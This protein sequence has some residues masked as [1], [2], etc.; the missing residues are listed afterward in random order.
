MGSYQIM[1][2]RGIPI[3]VHITL[4]ILLPLFAI[5]FA[6][7]LGVLSFFWGLLTAAGLFACIALHELG[8][9]MVAIAKGCSVREILLLPIGGVAQ[10]NSIPRDPRDEMLMAIAGPA[11]S[12]ALAMV[13]T[14]LGHLFAALGLPYLSVVFASLGSFN[15]MLVLFNLLPS[16]PMD[17]GRV[18]RAWLSPRIGRLNATRMAAKVGQMMALGFGIWALFNWNPFLLVIA[19]F[20]YQAAGAEYRM[21][22]IQEAHNQNRASPWPFPGGRWSSADRDIHVSPPPYRQG[23]QASAF[24]AR[25]LRK[26]HDLFDDL[27]EKWR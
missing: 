22:L 1:T 27:F 16:F 9:S 7:G 8:H 18:F 12:L 5:T 21:V 20:I 25:P 2:V 6:Q 10:L 4:L 19:V 11:V 14:L 3:R 23:G 13:G 15:L 17:G 24:F 26:Q